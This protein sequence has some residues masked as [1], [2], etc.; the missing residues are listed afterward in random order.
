MRG[1]KAPVNSGGHQADNTFL[2][3]LRRRLITSRPLPAFIRARKPCTFFLC[4]F[5]GWYVWSIAGNTSGFIYA[6]Q[7]WCIG[8][9]LY[10]VLWLKRPKTMPHDYIISLFSCQS[11]W[12]GITLSFFCLLFGVFIIDYTQAFWYYIF[13]PLKKGYDFPRV[14]LL[15]TTA[16]FFR[17]YISKQRIKRQTGVHL[18]HRL[19]ITLW[20]NCVLMSRTF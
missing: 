17:K 11:N 10:H 8:K 20:I 5:F 9:C 16:K 4:L 15:G 19:W 6:H 7:I 12:A 3:L 13:T 14:G 2:P 1:K 18:I